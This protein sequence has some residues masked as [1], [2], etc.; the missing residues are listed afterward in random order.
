M[1]GKAKSLSIYELRNFWKT[2]SHVTT[3]EKL[4]LLIE[5]VKKKVEIHNLEHNDNATADIVFTSEIEIAKQYT[6]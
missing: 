4:E 3:I 5:T 1:S 2:H 6:L